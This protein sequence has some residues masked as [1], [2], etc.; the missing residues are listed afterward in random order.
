MLWKS[1][2][3]PSGVDNARAL[4]YHVR[5]G[6]VS[7]GTRK[8]GLPSFDREVYKGV[9]VIKIEE[10]AGKG[11]GSVVPGFLP[12]GQRRGRDRDARDVEKR[13][14]K[15]WAKIGWA[16]SCCSWKNGLEEAIERTFFSAKVEQ[17]R[18]SCRSSDLRESLVILE[19][20]HT[21]SFE[22]A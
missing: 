11:V 5:V 4:G 2:Q 13:H 3:P 19:G 20:G 17:E 15:D 7:R 10:V 6:T 16:E 12:V 9:D 14:Q 8:V 21:S 1:W 18:A 22:G